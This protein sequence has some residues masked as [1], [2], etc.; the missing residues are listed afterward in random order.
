MTTPRPSLMEQSRADWSGRTRTQRVKL[1][2]WVVLTFLLMVYQILTLIYGPLAW[3]PAVARLRGQ[4]LYATTASHRTFESLDVI[5]QSPD[6][7]WMAAGGVTTPM[8]R[9][10][11][12]GR[13]IIWQARSLERVGTF[14]LPSAQ[15]G[16]VD[17]LR[18]APDSRSLAVMD[19]GILYA[20]DR[21]T[22]RVLTQVQTHQ[23]TACVLAFVPGGLLSTER[24]GERG[25][26]SLVLRAWPSLN[27]QW[28]QPLAC[29]SA[30][31]RSS[32]D[33]AGTL[34]AYAPDGKDGS[35]ELEHLGL[36][37]LKTRTPL[38]PL[39]RRDAS[40]YPQ[41]LA[42]HPDGRTVA[43]G[44]EDG[45][46]IVWDARAGTELWR[47]KPHGDL[48]TS[49]AWSPDGRTLASAGFGLCGQGRSECMALSR[50]VGGQVSSQV[51]WSSTNHVPDTLSWLAPDRVLLSADRIA[52]VV[53]VPAE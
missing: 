51:I 16:G 22:G 30:S 13:V 50:R 6:G 18:W 33:A 38:P 27:V 28:R 3:L 48:V 9:E 32:I 25:P 46:V 37:D 19:G 49:L 5:R 10:Q 35:D 29:S 23:F 39:K 52:Q 43:A 12:R 42:V 15:S 4:Q 26:T 53:T 20:L 36:L 34:L 2:A 17:D 8:R 45:T 14:T 47:S 11:F 7:R 41:S 1:V 21:Q 24:A 44:Y 31:A 40:G